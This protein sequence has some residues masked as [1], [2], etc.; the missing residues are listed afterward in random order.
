MSNLQFPVQYNQ[1]SSPSCQL[2]A[3]DGILGMKCFL[4]KSFSVRNPFIYSFFVE[5]WSFVCVATGNSLGFDI[6]M[7]LLL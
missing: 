3:Q 1:Y 7:V 6:G 2:S 5:M 4:K